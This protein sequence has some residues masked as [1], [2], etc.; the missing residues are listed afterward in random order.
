[1]I[2]SSMGAMHLVAALAAILLG[3]AVILLPKGRAPHRLLGLA[4]S[5]AMLVT[6]ISALLLY[7]MTGHFGLFHFFAVLC[8][9]YVALGVAQAILRRGDWMRRHL[10]WMGWSYIGLLAATATEASI[11][12][13]FFRHLT[14]GQTFA[15]GGAIAAVFLVAGWLM[16]PRWT[17][18]A[19]ARFSP[20]LN[21]R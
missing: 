14:N 5:F 1:M 6:C 11:R 19:L 13:P 17:R 2:H 12:F 3:L 20:A 16:M 18:I 21:P 4:Y 8:L 9:V 7:G 15:L 10:T